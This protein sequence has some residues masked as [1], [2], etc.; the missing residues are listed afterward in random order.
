MKRVTMIIALLSLGTGPA[1]AATPV[2]TTAVDH[3][4]RAEGDRMTTALNLLEAKGYASFTGFKADGDHYT[5]AV[6]QNGRSFTVSINP[7]NGQVTQQ[8]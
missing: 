1:L 4:A 6:M 3:R 8:G 5:A 7:D 2:G